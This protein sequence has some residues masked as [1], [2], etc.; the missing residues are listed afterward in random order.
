MTDEE[1]GFVIKDKRHFTSEGEPLEEEKVGKTAETAKE[2]PPARAET[3]EDQKAEEERQRPPLP[4]VT[5]S[6]FVFSL[7]SSVVLH[8]GEVADPGTGETRKDLDLAK[9]T[10]DIISMLKDK[11]KGNLTEEEQNMVDHALY[12]LRM[13]YVKAA[14]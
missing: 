14:G 2:E 10:I 4:E 3:A 7:V 8:L 1:K 9:H 6:T 11:T 12:D 5:F 13:R